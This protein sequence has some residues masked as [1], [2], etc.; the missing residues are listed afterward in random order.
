[1]EACSAECALV[2]GM[3]VIGLVG[4]IYCVTMGCKC[5]TVNVLLVR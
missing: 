3:T 4:D 1:M 5:L 2:C